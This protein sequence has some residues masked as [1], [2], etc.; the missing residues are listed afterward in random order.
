MKRFFSTLV[1]V[2]KTSPPNQSNLTGHHIKSNRSGKWHNFVGNHN[3]KIKDSIIKIGFMNHN[4]LIY[5]RNRRYERRLKRI[6]EGGG[7]Q[8]SCKLDFEKR[9]MIRIIPFFVFG[10]LFF[11]MFY[12]YL[13]Q[14]LY[15][16]DI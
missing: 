5:R 12:S 15:H 10:F 13:I 2:I 16:K 8:L 3:T 11:L 14:Q 4:S 7:P 9:Q 1:G 6:S